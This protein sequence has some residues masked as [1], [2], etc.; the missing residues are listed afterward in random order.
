MVRWLLA[1]PR[2]V[3]KFLR[4]ARP[5]LLLISYPGILD[6]FVIAPFA[7]M[8]RIPVAWDV[9]LSMYDTV[10]E[11]RRLLKPGSAPA[12][13]LRWLERAA[14][15]RA[16]L[17]FMDTHAHARR[18]EQL[19]GLADGCCDAV[20]VG[21][22]SRF[23]S[24][25]AGSK[26]RTST[27]RVLFYGQFIPLHGIG[28]IIAAAALL[29]DKPIQWHL[30]GRG[31]EAERIRKM[32]SDDPLPHVQWTDWVDYAQLNRCI[33]DADL[34]LGI[35]GTSDKA[36][37]VIPNKVFQIVAAGRPLI[38][39]DSPAIRELLSPSPPCS[40]L[41]SPGDAHALA[42][43]VLTHSRTLLENDTVGECHGHL[44]DRIDAAAIGRQ[45]LCVIERSRVG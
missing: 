13:V 2:L 20:W 22:E 38:T 27:M 5:D 11:D 19:F 40:Y 8:R 6:A 26:P 3:W 37:S 9:F 34:C 42:A 21:V 15:R 25:L 10:C 30:V 43:A 44:V 14:L 31:Q 1:Y 28:T 45:F 7:R 33:A 39:R 18:L 4:I 12:R 23:F 41:V 35:F 17:L 29:R 32:L 24:R 36:A 16:D